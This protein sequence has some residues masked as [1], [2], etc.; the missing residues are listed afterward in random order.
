MKVQ[1]SLLTRGH[2]FPWQHWGSGY[3]GGGRTTEH[4]QRGRLLMS[5]PSWVRG[6]NDRAL[7]HQL[8]PDR[9][10]KKAF[11]NSLPFTR[12]RMQG[13]WFPPGSAGI[14]LVLS[15]FLKTG[16]GNDGGL[17][18]CCITLRAAEQGQGDCGCSQRSLSAQIHQ[19]GIFPI[20][21]VL[22]K[23]PA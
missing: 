1:S 5:E 6:E 19:H 11:P 23:D 7:P 4:R 15:Y 2:G 3:G 9:A 16:R 22:H 12:R 10:E 13:S 20:F 14:L 18:K 17:L 21:N 8:S